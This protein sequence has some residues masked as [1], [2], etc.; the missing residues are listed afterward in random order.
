MRNKR[1]Y[2]GLRPG[3]VTNFILCKFLVPAPS[4]AANCDI[5]PLLTRGPRT[6]VIFS[7]HFISNCM[8]CLFRQR[9]HEKNDLL[10]SALRSREF[11]ETETDSCLSPVVQI[12]HCL[13]GQMN[14]NGSFVGR[15][16]LI[17]FRITRNDF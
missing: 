1:V 6:S 9:S 2:A 13:F 4:M 17:K 10:A 15:E 11:M 7:H 16:L 14:F 5:P 12:L 8:E 3:L